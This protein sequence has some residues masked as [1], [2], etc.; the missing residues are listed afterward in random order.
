MI[1]IASDPKT[2]YVAGDELN[3]NTM[4][5]SD[6]VPLSFAVRFDAINVYVTPVAT[7][8]GIYLV[9]KNGENI[10]GTAIYSP[11]AKWNIKVRAYGW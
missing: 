4:G 7:P 3:P 2:G 8:S 6:H 5:D 10:G 1:N 9:G 11:W